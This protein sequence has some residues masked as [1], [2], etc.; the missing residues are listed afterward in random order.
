MYMLSSAQRMDG[1]A[2]KGQG[3][4]QHSPEE[5]GR[6]ASSPGGPMVKLGHF[7]TFEKV[8]SLMQEVVGLSEF[9]LR[10]DPAPVE[11]LSFEAGEGGLSSNSYL[12]TCKKHLRLQRIFESF[13][14][15]HK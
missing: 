3:T 5:G 7:L 1:R 15:L 13:P 10:A 6:V 12:F 9:D 2:A 14:G 4:N 11:L 8:D